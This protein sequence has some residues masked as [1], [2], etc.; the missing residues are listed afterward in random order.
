MA[1]S[2]G[3]ILRRWPCYPWPFGVVVSW[4]WSQ[5]LLHALDPHAFTT[6]AGE[7][8]CTEGEANPQHSHSH[9]E[10]RD[11]HHGL[12]KYLQLLVRVDS[13]A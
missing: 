1:A 2:V 4:L 10:N 3:F 5:L 11:P 8:V 12:H 6:C 13:A 9:E 7:E